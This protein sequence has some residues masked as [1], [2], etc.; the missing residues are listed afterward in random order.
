MCI[1]CKNVWLSYYRY[2]PTSSVGVINASIGAII[3]KI[4]Q[5]KDQIENQLKYYMKNDIS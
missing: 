1:V 3:L 5:N 2:L 4:S